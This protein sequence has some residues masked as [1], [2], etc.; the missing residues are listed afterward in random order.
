MQIILY[1]TVSCNRVNGVSL[2]AP[3]SLVSNFSERVDTYVFTPRC[4]LSTHNIVCCYVMSSVA[5]TLGLTTCHRSGICIDDSVAALRNCGE[6][7]I[8]EILRTKS[9]RLTTKIWIIW[10]SFKRTKSWLCL[11]QLLKVQIREIF[12]H[13][14]YFCIPR[15]QNTT[16]FRVHI[17]QIK[18]S[19]RSDRPVVVSINWRE[20]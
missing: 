16:L 6:R 8:A 3:L 1:D 9:E 17:V 12:Q 11:K 13:C 2:R 4:P 5:L 18:I 19:Q 10:F 7:Q 20:Q 15:K 14:V